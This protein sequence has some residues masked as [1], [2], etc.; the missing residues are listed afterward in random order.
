MMPIVL[1]CKHCGCLP[2][3][4]PQSANAWHVCCTAGCEKR[5]GKNTFTAET[6][7]EAITEWNQANIKEPTK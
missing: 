4:M 6:E 3:L 5:H 7:L 2:Y 1:H